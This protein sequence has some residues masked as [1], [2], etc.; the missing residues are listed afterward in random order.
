MNGRQRNITIAQ[1][2]TRMPA[3]AG[4]ALTMPCKGWKNQA[5]SIPMIV[6]TC[7]SEG[8]NNV[9][10]LER[11]MPM[12]IINATKPYPKTLFEYELLICNIILI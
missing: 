7:A 4:R 9:A 6:G 2:I 3:S 10:S 5:G 12:R 8:G 11:K 1:E